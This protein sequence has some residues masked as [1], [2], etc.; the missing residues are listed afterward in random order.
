MPNTLAHIGLQVP[1]TRLGLKKAPLQWIIVGCI[2]PD[3]PWIVQRILTPLTD[4][5]TLR[6]YTVTQ[7]SLIYCLLLCLALSMLTRNSRYIFFVLAGNSLAH[8]LIDAT[9]IKWGNGVNLLVPFSW[10]STNFGLFWPEHISSY[11]CT[12][13]G[14]LICLF[15][16]PKA[17]QNDLSL[18]KPTKRKAIYASIC[19]IF[20]FSSPVL[21]ISSAYNADVHYSQSLSNTQERTG[22]KLEIDRAQFNTATNTLQCYIDKNLKIANMSLMESATIS[23]RGQFINNSTIELQN[24]HT[25]LAFRDFASYAG[26]LLAI[27]LWTH[28][29][30]YKNIS[31]HRNPK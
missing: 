6:L 20:Y 26:I 30:I 1:L 14:F 24:V 9:Q 10:Y 5:L 23:I 4:P 28:S 22:K 31:P 18:Q 21:L 15:L 3:I 19:L 12:A 7:A 16:W 11:I 27:L 25:H 29:L 8:L 2:I 13:I 17:I